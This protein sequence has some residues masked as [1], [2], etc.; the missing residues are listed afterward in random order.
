MH[1][2]IE[3]LWIGDCYDARN[4]QLLQD[5]GITAI[6]SA[7]VEIPIC[8]DV[9]EKVLQARLD[10]T[11]H[12]SLYDASN[13]AKQED[14][15]RLAAA[16]IHEWLITGE[17]VLVHCAAG[18]SRSTSCVLAYLILYQK[19]PIAIAYAFVKMKRSCVR[20]NP[21]FIRTLVDISLTK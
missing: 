9:F 16:N 6:L 11:L 3:G 19:I 1:E 17:R 5:N 15:F 4:I 8:N 2:I 13:A 18:V 7:A 10:N 12:L 20:P 21:G 14:Y